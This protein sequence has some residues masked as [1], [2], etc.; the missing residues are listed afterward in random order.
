M[1]QAVYLNPWVH[2]T[3][4]KP[5]A[6]FMHSLA[7][8]AYGE[9]KPLQAPR[10]GFSQLPSGPNRA[11]RLAEL[12]PYFPNCAA[13]RKLARDMKFL[14]PTEQPRKITGAV[15]RGLEAGRLA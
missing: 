15:R 14:R 10:R 6:R 5:Y 7:S 8:L 12:Q 9:N 4:T 11:A 1:R 2:N 13:R 3:S